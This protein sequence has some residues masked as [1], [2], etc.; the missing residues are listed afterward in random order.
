MKK[1]ISISLCLLLIIGIFPQKQYVNA[2]VSASGDVPVS[3]IKVS[4]SFCNLRIGEKL[5]IKAK[6]TP[7]DATN[8]SL[9][10][11]VSDSCSSYVTISEDGVVKANKS[12]VGKTVRVYVKSTDGSNVKKYVVVNILPKINPKKKMIALTFDD[13]PN[14]TSNARIVKALKKNNAVGTFF[15]LGSLLGSKG[16]RQEIRWMARQG[17]EI[18]SHTQ[19]HL[20]LSKLSQSKLNSEI[21]KT[22][23]MLK[24]LLGSKPALVRTP[25]GDYSTRVLNAINRPMIMWSVDTLDWKTRNANSTYNAVMKQ[26]R[27]GSIVLMHSIYDASA[28]AAERIVP[29][30]KSKG[31]Q[32]VTVS[33]LFK[34][35]GKKLS[36]AK[37]Y[38]N[39]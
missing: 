38:C 1:F 31:Y 14:T 9:T 6:V 13:G 22:D 33:E 26:A 2:A 16:N 20:Q 29:K 23:Q 37:V 17:M 32:M 27:D 12:A 3:K 35:R 25:Y 10:Y 36:K 24:N 19:N 11:Y 28:S 7:S 5:K 8:S 21:S 18:G 30:L 39:E 34:Y 15:V 4:K